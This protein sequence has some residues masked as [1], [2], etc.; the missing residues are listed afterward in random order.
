MISVR[1]QVEPLVADG[2]RVVAASCRG[3]GASSKHYD[4]AM[5]GDQLVADQLR[6]L[7]ALAID[8]A[9]LGAYPRACQPE[10]KGTMEGGRRVCRT[11]VGNR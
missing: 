1:S 11:P 10:D 4:P 7:D 5:Y 9:H 6:L 3:M 2:F 8:K